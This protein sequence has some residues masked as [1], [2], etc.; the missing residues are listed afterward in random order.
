M[1]SRSQLARSLQSRAASRRAEAFGAEALCFGPQLAFVRDPS[2]FKVAVCSRRA[3]KTTG[4]AV[5]LL[6][7]AI[8]E[9]YTNQFYVTKTLKNARKIIWPE[10]KRLNREYGLGGVPNETEAYMRFPALPGEPCIYLAGAKDDS[11]SD[12][13]RGLKGK[14]AVVDEPQSMRTSVLE[15]LMKDAVRPALWDYAGSLWVTGTPG[16]VRAGYFYDID[17]GEQSSRW[18]HHH[19]TILDNPWIQKLS[20]RPPAE[21]L[22]EERDQRG[23]GEDDPTYQR[24]AMGRWVHDE[25]A[26]VF[27]FEPG[28]HGY[29]TLPEGRMTHVIGCDLGFNDADAI[30]VLGWLPNSNTV[31]LV[32]EYVMPKQGMTPFM[33]ALKER[34]TKYRP[35]KVVLDLG[36]IAKK[37]VED[38]RG[39]F[40]QSLEA[41]DKTRKFEHIEILNDAIKAGRFKARPLGNFAE[42]AA[43]VQWDMDARAKGVLKIAE[44]YHS[45]ITDAVLYAFRACYAHLERP[46]P[47]PPADERQAFLAKLAA[48][49]RSQTRRDPVD[50]FLGYRDDE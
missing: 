31:Y 46:A 47:P 9:P 36:G 40:T 33:A 22:R 26:L 7:D 48:K 23:V 10:L 3:G 49:Q 41:A 13:I 38:W 18:S 6:E 50:A 12:N 42:D 25:S 8:R 39:R 45:D 37:A 43:L 28:T 20:G 27:K 35:I 2:R 4:V 29:E 15:K 30:A 44:D 11:E 5:S 24:E 19:W 17:Q 1:S 14:K 34:V 32:D 16:P 21:L